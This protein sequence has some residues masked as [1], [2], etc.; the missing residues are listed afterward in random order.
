MTEPLPP[1]SNPEG[2]P[3]G[4]FFGA[5]LM[6]VGTLIG[7]LSGLCSLGF[8]VIM[9]SEPGG[10]SGAVISGLAMVAVIGGVPF[11]FG[12]VIFFVG[13][14]LYRA[15]RPKLPNLAKTFE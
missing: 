2:N 13:R 8:F 5:L 11:A 10:N 12:L 14:G 9:L 1:Q 15:S 6:V 7:L 4:R 3:G